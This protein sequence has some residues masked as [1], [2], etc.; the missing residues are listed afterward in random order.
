MTARRVLYLLLSAFVCYLLFIVC[1]VCRSPIPIRVSLR[2]LHVPCVCTYT[3]AP[4][5]AR[6]VR[7]AYRFYYR[8][9]ACR[10]TQRTLT[11]REAV[12]RET[13]WR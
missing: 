7:C 8:L 13:T 3:Y 5:P 11:T 4:A 6:A 1:V 12:S 10:L 2:I 9:F